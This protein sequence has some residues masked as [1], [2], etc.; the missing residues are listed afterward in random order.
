MAG[1]GAD[2]RPCGWGTPSASPNP[3]CFQ[4]PLCPETKSICCNNRFPRPIEELAAYVDEAILEQ[5]AGQIAA[6]LYPAGG[7]RRHERELWDSI[8]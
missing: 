8:N 3:R 6:V 7:K 1:A 5:V 2:A 4:P